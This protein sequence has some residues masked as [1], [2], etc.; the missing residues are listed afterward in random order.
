MH[1]DNYGT[2][3]HMDHVTPCDSFDA[4]NED[5]LKKC[6]N[7]KNLRPLKGSE[8]ISKSAKI[9]IKDILNQEIKVHYYIQ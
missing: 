7:W 3:W 4:T 9:I 1:W 5:Q 8:N 2:Y 6:F